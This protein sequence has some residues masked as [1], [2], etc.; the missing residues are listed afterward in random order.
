M[1]EENANNNAAED[2]NPV[3]RMQKMYIKDFSFENPNAPGVFQAQNQE[4]K[5]EVNLKLNNKKLDDNH[6]EVALQITAKILDSGNNNK[7]MFIMEIEHAAA[8][9]MR[10]IPAEHLEMVL[11]VDCPTLLFPFTRQIV[12]QISVDGG[13]IPFLMEPINFMALYQNSKQEA[14]AAKN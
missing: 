4:P 1:T 10:N 14:A 7:T 13:F 2:T 9:L 6:Y 12:S 5:V 11:G 3:F 8:F